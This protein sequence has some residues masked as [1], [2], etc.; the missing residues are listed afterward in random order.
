MY[1]VRVVLIGAASLFL[2]I[3]GCGQE[4]EEKLDRAAEHF[5]KAVDNAADAALDAAEKAGDKLE[6][7]TDQATAND[8]AKDQTATE[9]RRDPESGN[10]PR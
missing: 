9:Q 7:W 10:D 3:T 2:G 6:Q 8:D 1:S 4:Q 5:G